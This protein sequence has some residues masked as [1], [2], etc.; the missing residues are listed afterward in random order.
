[1]CYVLAKKKRITDGH[2]LLKSSFF[3]A[4]GSKVGIFYIPNLEPDGIELK[5]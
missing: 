2:K 1:M 5:K 3:K 4:V